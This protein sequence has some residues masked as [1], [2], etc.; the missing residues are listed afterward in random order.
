[1]R[2][3]LDPNLA[4]ESAATVQLYVVLMLTAAA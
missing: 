1:M 4:R 3:A 2:A